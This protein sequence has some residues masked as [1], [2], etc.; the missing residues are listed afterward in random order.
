M[1][2]QLTSFVEAR[3]R[4]RPEQWHWEYKRWKPFNRGR[5]RRGF[6]YVETILVHAP[7]RAD[8]IEDVLPACAYLK[9]AYPHSR[10]TVLMEATVSRLLRDCPHVD[11]V[12]EYRR[13]RGVRGLVE[14]TRVIRRVR[15][16][17]FHVAV[18]LAESFRPVLWATLAGI[19]L[20][21]GEGGRGRGCLLTHAVARAKPGTSAADRFLQVASRIARAPE[22]GRDRRTGA[23]GAT[24]DAA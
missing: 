8:E 3:V 5:F 15:R 16:H 17:Y 24:T 12:I 7:A 20:R 19:P 18:L 23:A 9:A 22:S 11:E 2:Q 21:V 1:T 6:R 4:E 10:L 13:R 14:A